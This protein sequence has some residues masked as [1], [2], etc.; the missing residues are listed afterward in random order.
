MTTRLAAEGRARPVPFGLWRALLACALAVA[1]VLHL[2]LTPDHFSEST[3]MGLGFA[4]AT[5]AELG[6]AAAVLARSSRLVYAAV[7]VVSAILVGLYVYNVFIGLP[8]AGD[9]AAAVVEQVTAVESVDERGEIEHHEHSDTA[10]HGE[11]A[12]HDGH[13]T[14]GLVLG[15]GEPVDAPGVATKS[16]ELVSI[17]IAAG[18]LIRERRRQA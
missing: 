3:L 17:G 16:A 18:L 4:A 7:V 15:S 9:R 8:F 14:E 2:M 10:G 12:E 5:A 6:L 11:G 1:G 13:H